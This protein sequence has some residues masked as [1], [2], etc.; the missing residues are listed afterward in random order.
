MS[1]RARVS[2]QCRFQQ[3]R[4]GL[5]C[6]RRRRQERQRRRWERQEPLKHLG[7]NSTALNNVTD[8]RGD[9]SFTWPGACRVG[10]ECKLQRCK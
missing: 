7:G 5:G 9:S 2:G 6:A 10:S 8:T 1:L 3:C 4:C